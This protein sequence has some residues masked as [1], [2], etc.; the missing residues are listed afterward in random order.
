MTFKAS[1]EIRTYGT[2]TRDETTS[3]ESIMLIEPC[4]VEV[5]QHDIIQAADSQG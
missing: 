5:S 4:R 2:L 1:R 3:P